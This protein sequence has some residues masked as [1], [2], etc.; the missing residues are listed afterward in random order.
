VSVKG[1]S[2]ATAVAAGGEH[3]LALLAGGT[4]MAWGGDEYCQLGYHAVV[5][6]KE[7]EE[8]V[9]E[10]EEEPFSDVPVSVKGLSGVTSLAAGGRHS[11]ALL[12]N[13]TAMAW[14]AGA[15][16]Q[17]GN[18]ALPSCQASPVAV[19]GLS[20][21]S[22]VSAGAEDSVALLENGS[23]RD[24]GDNR[25]G[26]LGD[27]H[28]GG[29]SDVPVAVVGLGE[30]IGIAAGGGFEL[31][32]SEPIPAVTSVS[33]AIGA[34][35]GET[36]VTISGANFEE[37]AQVYF[38][39]TP[40]RR[41]VV[42][43]PTSITAY[44]PAGGVG[45]VDITVS[46]PAGRSPTVTADRFTYLPPPTVKK[47]SLKKGP[48]T[49]GSTVTITGTGF[50]G[51]TKVSFGASEAEGV[52]VE[53]ASTITVRSP[54]EAGSVDVTVAAAGGTSPATKKDLFEY[55]PAVEALAPSSGPVAGGAPVTISGAGF[56]LGAGATAFKLGSKYATEVSC[57]SHTSCSALTPAGKPGAV[58]VQ[59]IVGKAK[60]A[61]E[62][63]DLY[64]YE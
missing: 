19:S 60:S 27:G 3:S 44:S 46:N 22:A 30:T 47:L 5:I 41:F 33:P 21:V 61:A 57:V 13:G 29:F 16:G 51:V 40:A 34:E 10:P 24:W 55:V 28:F 38:G 9:E 50:E 36:E 53:S 7:E 52:K 56:A 49:G 62:P 35:A 23:V 42:D 18:G 43:S 14:G 1:I 45:T 32:Y 54:P 2:T 37:V 64:T 11:L 17:L 63:G 4:V 48:G 31:A 25:S 12:S 26:E 39:S 8:I 15:S 58:A 20:G 59:A 6:R